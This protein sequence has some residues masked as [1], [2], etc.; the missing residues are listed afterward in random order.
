MFHFELIEE[1]K[2]D[3]I[4]RKINM[5]SILFF[6][7]IFFL[8]TAD[9]SWYDPNW[10][11]RRPIV[12]DNTS[13]S[14]TLYDFQVGLNI[15]YY[16]EMQD[17]FDDIRYTTDDEDTSIPYWIEEYSLSTSAITWVKIP[18]VPALDTA[19]IYLY[20]GN[21]NAASENNGEAV[22]DFFDD[23]D[24]QDISDW[25]VISGEWSAFN[26]YLEQ[27]ETANH[28][29]I[30]SPYSVTNARVIEGKMVYISSYLYSGNQILISKDSLANNGYKFGYAGL[31]AGG[32]W[33]AKIVS[34]SVYG[35]VSDSTI[36]TANYAYIWLKA[37]FSYDGVNKL[38]FL[39]RTPDSIEVFLETND[40]TFSIPFFLG[41]YCGSHIGID[42]LRVRE[43]TDTEPSYTI[44]EEEG[45]EEKTRNYSRVSRPKLSLTSSNLGLPIKLLLQLPSDSWISGDIYDCAG[46]EICSPIKL[47]YLKRGFCNLTLDEGNFYVTSG[48]MFLR[49]TINETNGSAFYLNKKI[50]LLQ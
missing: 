4:Y 25:T 44:K 3:P 13:N 8:A 32:T 9:A 49:V 40:V 5:E 17:D 46:R 21:P 20:Y 7:L 14:D 23:F 10:S 24:D 6:I 27:S 11:S 15:P 33:I 43:Y 22:F 39:L 42:D 12:I 19:I 37:K 35:L 41:V 36:N 50:M 16:S 45:V 18:I 34:G 26:K 1:I 48:I 38:N 29:K 28:R 47:Q 30:L 2:M 31:N